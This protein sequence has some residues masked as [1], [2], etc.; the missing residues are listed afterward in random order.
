MEKY[1]KICGYV[2]NEND[3]FCPNCGADSNNGVA[4]GATNQDTNMSYNNYEQNSNINNDVQQNTNM[5]NNVQ[6]TSNNM[7]NGYQQDSNMN[8]GYQQNQNMNYGYQQDP[9]MMN[10]GY[11]QNPNMYNNP[12]QNPNMNGYQQNPN[13][14]PSKY[15]GMAIASFCCSLGGL[16]VAG[17]IMGILAI[18]FAAYA[19]KRFKQFPQEKGKGL[20]TAGLVIG[21][22][23]VVLMIYFLSFS[24]TLYSLF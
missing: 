2:L 9:N 13:A 24:S 18:I 3:R 23:D 22:I 19:K 7:Y 21:I 1:C 11:Q 15:N 17:I 10:N 6:D 14:Y 4:E 20:A 16:V 12:Q 8:N 5:N